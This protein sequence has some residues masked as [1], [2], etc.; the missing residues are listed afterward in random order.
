MIISMTGYGRGRVVRDGYAVVAEL[1]SVNHRYLELQ[2]RLP[3]HYQAHEMFLRNRLQTLQRGK[4]TVTLSIDTETEGTLSAPVDHGRLKAYYHD[5]QQTAAELGAPPPTLDAVLALP[6]VLLESTSEVNETEWAIVQ[7]AVDLAVAELQAARQR[8]GENLQPQFDACLEALDAFVDGTEAFE[9]AR[10]DALKA[11]METGLAEL[12][13]NHPIDDGRFQQE[14]FY[15]L[16]K[17]DIAE[18][19]QR[20]RAHLQSFR[21]LLSAKESQGRQLQFLV[22]EL[23]REVNTLGNKAYQMDLQRQVVSMKEELEKLKEQLMNIQ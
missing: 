8:E 14:L 19:K 7:E 23:W 1:K 18:E 12:R 6:G 16:E 10:V 17:Y 9:A 13:A 2:F 15:Y 21:E 4:V 20:I 22:Q 5:L 11:K 3:G